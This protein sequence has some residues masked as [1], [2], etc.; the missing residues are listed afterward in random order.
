[1]KKNR[2]QNGNLLD[3]FKV[4]KDV[5]F[6]SSIV[7]VTDQNGIII[8]TNENFCKISGYKEEE[9]VGQNHR[10]VNSGFHTKAFFQ[11]MWNKLLAGE[12]W[13]GEICNRSKD[14]GL[15]WVDT[16]IT[17]VFN[18]EKEEYEF[19]SIRL[20]ITHRKRFEEVSTRIQSVANIG[21]WEWMVGK[22]SLFW[23]DEVFNIH[24]LDPKEYVPTL[25]EAKNFYAPE[26]KELISS[27]IQNALEKGQGWD[28][29]L[30][31]INK[32][33][34]RVWVRAVGHVEM[35]EGKAYRVYGTF[36]NIDR[37]KR[38]RMELAK[39]QMQLKLAVEAAG[40]A[41][42]VYLP[43]RD[44]L[45]WDDAA[46]DVFGIER[47][48]KSATFREWLAYIIPEH[49]MEAHKA[50][51]DAI[52]EKSEMYDGEYQIN[53][54]KKGLR[55]IK[56][57]ALITY[58]SEGE[59][60]EIVGL[61]WDITKEKELE[62]TLIEAREKA[63]EATQA[64]SA[65]LA[66][67]SHEIRTP[68]N[69]LMGTLELFSETKL[70]KEQREFLE[71]I[72]M[73]GEQLLNVVNDIL[74]FSKIEAGK[75]ELEYR[76]IDLNRLLKGVRAIFEVQAIKKGIELSISCGSEIP[77]Y[78]MGDETR[79]KQI[80]TNLISNAIKF[81]FKGKVEL[82]VEKSANSS[83]SNDGMVT[84]LFK[85]IDSGIG[86][87][88]N[89]QKKLFDSFSQVDASTTRKYG[90][91]G[92]GLAICKSLVN[93]MGGDIEVTSK[94][95]HGSTFT[96][97]IM[98]QI[99]EAIVEKEN[100]SEVCIFRKDL[101]ILL[102]EDNL[103]NQKLALSFLKKIGLDENQV[104]IANNGL[105]AF[106][107][108]EKSIEKGHPYD[109]I[110][111]D[112]QMPEMDGVDA[113]IKINEKFKDKAPLIF[114][115]TANVFEEDR[116]RCLDAG[117]KA[118]ATKPIKKKVLINLFNEYF[119]DENIP[120]TPIT[121]ESIMSES[122]K[123]NY[124]NA[125]KILFEFG[126]DFDIFEELVEDYKS[127]VPEFVEK[128][129]AGVANHDAEVIKVAGHTLKG[130]VG[131]FYCDKLKDAAFA[132]EVAGKE[133]AIDSVE[134]KLGIF[135]SINE[136]VNQELVRFLEENAYRSEAA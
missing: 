28:L 22:D 21:Y 114:A 75:L 32:E 10:I 136:L 113:S 64:K 83:K 52:S 74:D 49:Q 14:G 124:L 41:S 133:G 90:G 12:K 47:S 86:I 87:P 38:T 121:G 104:V 59:P 123:Y 103:T 117:M 29:E 78:I 40:I 106:Q 46:H 6:D 88:L 79:L 115:M 61:N 35:I 85:V 13:Q 94:H 67:M 2:D 60:S 84:L 101:H 18:E 70:N 130:I 118:F 34:E 8:L 19:I 107:L 93:S 120:I 105:E 63:V 25:E 26:F 108:V 111:M 39:S 73:S 3:F 33:K 4:Y 55:F 109:A 54:P 27:A 16:S 58:N 131:N 126:E 92:L 91:S 71:T 11:D 80:L 81:T 97:E 77:K 43:Q 15:Y 96:F 56:G 129:Q 125:E 9:L 30:Q 132:I 50:F 116:K 128:I 48:K 23:S 36:Q 98:T 119:P 17:P 37:R 102:A 99:G 134:E 31:I 53:H 100:N 62:A 45:T 76:N 68:M 42:W 51:V 122:N 24:G 66:S 89:K 82:Q 57:R 69:G 112:M 7:S 44:T 135:L 65:F 127:Q 1:M 20:E 72:Q 5:A 110:L 95:G